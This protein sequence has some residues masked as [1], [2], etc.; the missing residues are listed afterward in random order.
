MSRLSV[1]VPS[2]IASLRT[3]L[4]AAMTPVHFV[5]GGTDML[6][7]GRVPTDAGLLVDL[8]HVADMSII[9]TEGGH[10]RIGA[11]TTVAALASHDGLRTRLPALSDAAVQCGSVQIRNR[12]TIGGNIANA[13]PAADL[14]P[15]LHAAGALLG[16]IE[17]NGA[18]SEVALADFAAAPGRLIVEI[19]LPEN[20]ILPC[21]A[22]VKL[23][24]RRDLTIAR[25]SLALLAELQNG[26]FGA[27]RI[28]AGAIGPIPLRLQLAEAA[29]A[30]RELG[31]A[32][33][34]DFLSALTAEVDAAIPGR[35]SRP[36]KRRAIAGLGLDLIARIAGLSTADPLFEDATA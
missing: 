9:T 24:P 5:A 1:V 23:G 13:S 21:S 36:Y 28:T 3:L 4:A 11:A 17:R 34:R 12:A 15:V 20:D 8:S 16:L 30:G 29:L 18:R 6:I 33:L 10:I 7:A 19:I 27:V 31:A 32:T 35:S 2:D 26:H 14:L 25:L 22:F